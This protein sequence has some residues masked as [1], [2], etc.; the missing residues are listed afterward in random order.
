VL[1]IL[2]IDKP[3]GITSHDVV[4]RIRKR[5]NTKRVGHAG[6]LDPN[7]TGLLVVAIGPATRFLQYL[8]L[9]P[10]VYVGEITFG[11]ETTTQD[12]E[13]EVVAA[14]PPPA[15]LRQAFDTHVGQFRG[16]IDQI[17]PA[18][19]AVKKEGKPLY[20]YARKGI[21]VERESRR[22]HIERFDL[23]R[24]LDEN[25]IEVEI[26]CSGGTYVRTLAHDLGQ[27][28]GCGAHLSA[29]MRTRVGRFEIKESKA[30]DDITLADLIPLR[31]ALMPPAPSAGLNAAQVDAIR[32]GRAVVTRER[33][34]PEAVV[35]LDPKDQVVGMAR[36][37]GNELHPECVIPA[38]ALDGS[39]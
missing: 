26:E 13:G 10:K 37:Q 19:S 18:Y 7:A 8:P 12:V 2:L 38:E 32:H 21:Q 16:L 25:R 28:A 6:T 17:P 14:K 33:F 1:G 24:V 36:Y 35:L 34:G 4:A 39:L 3:I 29:L 15:D 5:F 31:E 11:I 9:E 20:A 30:L 23:L 27:A 22:V